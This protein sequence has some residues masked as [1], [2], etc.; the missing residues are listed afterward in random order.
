[1]AHNHACL[2]CQLTATHHR[3][4]HTTKAV[5]TLQHASCCDQPGAQQ[6]VVQNTKATNNRNTER[7]TASVVSCLW[8][9]SIS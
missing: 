4:T 2:L 6:V 8:C 1:M 3:N 7:V 5:L 9:S